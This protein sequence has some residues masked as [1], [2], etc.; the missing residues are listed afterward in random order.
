MNSIGTSSI[1]SRDSRTLFERCK[2]FRDRYRVQTSVTLAVLTA[3]TFVGAQIIPAIQEYVVAKGV[4]LY[5]SLLVLLDLAVSIHHLQRPSSSRVTRDQDESMPMLV[6]A[7]ACCRTDGADLLEYA[8][9]TT[10]P[11][12]RAIRRERVPMR[13]L[14]KHPETVDGLQRHRNITALDTMYA[15]IFDNYDGIFEIRC[16]KL[17]F[18]L[19][20]RRLGREIL[21]VGWLT[22]DVK[23]STAFGHSN[24]SIVADLSDRG[25]AHLR[26]FFERTFE[27]L[28]NDENTED[29]RVVL[30]RLQQSKFREVASQPANEISD[31]LVDTSVV[32]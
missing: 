2:A 24:P 16:Y 9:S 28:W 10:L 15:S 6:D 22:P 23:R 8:G 3:L 4:L 18:S 26:D 21:E 25:N 27:M 20:G 7:V 19:R 17:P 31:Q 30:A 14:V 13:M 1:Q 11:L 5:L 29:G 12:I 32:S